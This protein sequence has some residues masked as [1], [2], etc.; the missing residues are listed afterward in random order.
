MPINPLAASELL[1]IAKY[2]TS[3]SRNHGAGESPLILQGCLL[4]AWRASQNSE[5]RQAIQRYL[6]NNEPQ[7]YVQT[8]H[9]LEAAERSVLASE[10]TQKT[11]DSINSAVQSFIGGVC[12]AGPENLLPA[13]NGMKDKD[14]FAFGLLMSAA[15]RSLKE[16]ELPSVTDDSTPSKRTRRSA[17]SKKP[18]LDDPTMET[19]YSAKSGFQGG[20]SSRVDAWNAADRSELLV[21][22]RLRRR[23]GTLSSHTLYILVAT[24]EEA[25]MHIV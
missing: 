20:V 10:A 14:R 17:R 22:Q 4:D 7:G 13:L 3:V 8:R 5:E 6:E 23:S 12:A 18:K 19:Q 16:L 21:E 15:E 24:T 25:M 2:D 1:E 11:K 9:V